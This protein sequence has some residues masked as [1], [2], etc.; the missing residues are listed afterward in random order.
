MVFFLRLL[1]PP[2]HEFLPSADQIDETFAE[3]TGL[4]KED[5]INAIKRMEEVNPMLGLR[6]CRLGIIMPELV[7]MQAR[8]LI[9]AAL[10]NK[11]KGL[12]PK[13]EVMVPLVG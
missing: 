4:S 3:E 1:D 12:N 10:N 5:C 6:G 8:A 9:E 13:P 2:L 7:E 11:M